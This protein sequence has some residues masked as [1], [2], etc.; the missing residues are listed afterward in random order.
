VKIYLYRDEWW[1]IIDFCEER[2]GDFDLEVEIDEEE[3]EFIK[4]AFG[5]FWKAQE[6]LLKYFEKMEGDK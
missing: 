5:M 6:I 2:C 4:K 3:F 1:P